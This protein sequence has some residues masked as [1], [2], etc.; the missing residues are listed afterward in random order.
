MRAEAENRSGAAFKAAETYISNMLSK[1][2]SADE[3]TPDLGGLPENGKPVMLSVPFDMHRIS[4]FCNEIGITPAHLFLASML[5]V[6][7]RFT[8]SRNAYINTISNGRTDIKLRNCFGMF[9][10]TLPIGIEIGDV[11]ALELVKAAKELLVNAVSNEIYPYADVCR[12]FNYA[13]NI[14]YAYQLGVSEDLYIDQQKI[15]NDA[16]G[17]RRV[18]FKTA[19]Y[20]EKTMGRK[21]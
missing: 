18:K 13:P 3:I 10:K 14:L 19:V 2:E 7:S 20:I 16:I 9:V 8:N 12:K 1:C 15:E 11:T 17:E 4:K 5:Y 6:V 21:V